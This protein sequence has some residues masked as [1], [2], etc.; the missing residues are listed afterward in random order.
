[1]ERR[2]GL[3]VRE[4]Q[5]NGG[6]E[7]LLKLAPVSW[8]LAALAAGILVA[9]AVPEGEDAPLIFMA[10]VFAGCGGLWA[11]PFSERRERR[12][13]ISLFL[14]AFAVR[15]GSAV[16]FDS[17]GASA[18]DP[19]AGSPDAWSYD[20]WARKLVSAW[21]ELRDLNLHAYNMAGRWDVGF[22][23][24][25]AVFYAIFGESILAGRLLV[26]FLGALAT[27][28]L[29]LVARRVAGDSVAA[30]AGLLYAFWISSVAWSGY[31]VLRDS[32][33][34]ALTLLAIWL[35]LRV[36]DGST[37]AGLGLF[38]GLVLLRTIRPYAAVFVLAGIGVAGVLAL[39]RRSRGAL[40]PTLILAAAVLTCELVFFITGFPSVFQMAGVYRPSQVLLK[41]MKEG[42]PLKIRS[43]PATVP[44]PALDGELPRA[45]VSPHLFGP[46]L[47]AN[48]LRFFLSPPG[49]AP[50]PGDIQRF[51]NWQLPGMW[52]WYAILPIAV[53]GF[54]LSARGS[55]SLRSITITAVIF[56]LMLILVGRGDSVRQREMVVPVFLLWFAIGLQQALRRPR[57]LIAVYLIYAA[58]FGAGIA[59]H[60]STLRAR[61]MVRLEIP[62]DWRP[63][64]LPCFRAD[65]LLASPLS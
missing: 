4:A 42:P 37:L 35:V 1:M 3:V 51:H 22:H 47:P 52:P 45:R 56:C 40:R 20:L 50:V 34:W 16:L 31:S 5:R 55:P 21:S 53:L 46:S 29:Y 12:R 27:V 9:Y 39:L 32:L 59:Y 49:W 41:P 11:F 17:L 58:I 8:G 6:I 64:T 26:A 60:R 65:A 38:L 25:L 57:R 24:I 2:H 7:I 63:P 19:Y 43:Y 62:P 61:G 28:F 23:Y 36:V 33:V 30:I 44:Q 48:T 54:F 13:L 14:L 18:G 10:L 15:V